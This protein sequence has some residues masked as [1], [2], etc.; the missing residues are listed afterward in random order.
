MSNWSHVL[1]TFWSHMYLL[2]CKFSWITEHSS[3]SYGRKRVVCSLSLYIYICIYIYIY[4]YIWSQT[5]YMRTTY[6]LCFPYIPSIYPLYA[7]YITLHTPYIPCI[8]PIDLLYTLQIPLIYPL[9]TPYIPLY[10]LCMSS[11]WII[12]NLSVIPLAYCRYNI[13][14]A[15]YIYIYTHECI[16]CSVPNYKY[17]EGASVQLRLH[18]RRQ[19]NKH[20]YIY[21]LF[22]QKSVAP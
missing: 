14:T 4:I 8:P 3:Q 15:I 17:L 16:D 11:I 20:I 7:H 12:Q 22:Y 9:Y 6:L 18:P 21:C 13:E 1:S 5:F 2:A 10:T 19:R